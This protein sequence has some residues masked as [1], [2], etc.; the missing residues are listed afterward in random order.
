MDRL[1]DIPTVQTAPPMDMLAS[2][3]GAINLPGGSRR[4]VRRLGEI[5][6]W[7]RS[8]QK[9]GLEFDANKLDYND[10]KR[11]AGMILAKNDDDMLEGSVG[12][13]KRFLTEDQDGSLLNLENFESMTSAQQRQLAHNSTHI[14]GTTLPPTTSTTITTTLLLTSKKIDLKISF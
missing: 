3:L 12:K 1:C 9:D 8:K 2:L 6:D 10:F 4:R 7:V 13:T 11:Q 14:N 5:L